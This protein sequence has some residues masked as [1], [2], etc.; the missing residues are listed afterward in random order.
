MRAT[1]RSREV[2]AGPREVSVM[3]RRHVRQS[4]HLQLCRTRVHLLEPDTDTLDD[5]EQDGTADGAVPG[6][7]VSASNRERAAREEA[8]NL[9]RVRPSVCKRYRGLHAIALYLPCC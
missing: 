4:T 6:R 7:L 9:R 2:V 3:D 5:G 1:F 8:G